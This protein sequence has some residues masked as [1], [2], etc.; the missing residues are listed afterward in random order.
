MDVLLTKV[1]WQFTLVFIDDIIILSQ[2]LEEHIR[3]FQL[4]LKLLH[5]AGLTLKLKKGKFF[6]VCIDYLGHV[7]RTGHFEWSTETIDAECRLEH[8]T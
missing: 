4:V 2:S 8:P 5:D 6:T 7:I 1:K 3:H